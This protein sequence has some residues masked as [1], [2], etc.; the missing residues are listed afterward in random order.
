[1]HIHQ[2]RVKEYAIDYLILYKQC[3]EIKMKSGQA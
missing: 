3:F 1:M 2:Q